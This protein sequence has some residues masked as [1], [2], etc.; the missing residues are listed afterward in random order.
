MSEKVLVAMSGG[1]DSSVAVKLLKSQG[2][3]CSGAIM[4]LCGNENT[5]D[6]LCVA[7]NVGVPF[8]CLDKTEKFKTDV[9]DKFAE[10]YFGGLTPNPCIECNKKMK[11]GFFL[12]YALEN[13]FDF[14]A[15]GHYARV[16]FNE[17][18]GLYELLRAADFSKDQSYVLYF[19]NQTQLQ[20]ILFPLGEYKKP[21]I[22]EMAENYSFVNAKKKDSQ[23]I[24]FVPSGDYAE[25]AEKIYGKKSENGNFKDING[26][27]LGA[28]KGIIHYTIGQR[29]GLGIALGKPTFVISKSTADNSVVLGDENYLFYKKVFV[30]DIN[31]ISG[32]SE[33]MPFRAQVKLR[34]AMQPQ[35]ATVTKTE[36]GAL[37]EFDI[38]Q[39]APSAG[40]AAVFYNGDIVL[41]GGTIVKGEN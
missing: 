13:G 10:D 28:H 31:L 30:K 33:F 8:C 26:K 3:I 22:R 11:F 21:E 14:I 4:R 25:V 15:T 1:V 39:R 35:N 7:E 17:S 41:G 23:D 18:T 19:L 20:H 40:Q 37:V 16:R 29:K 27:I 32:E 12:D 2:Y 9:M 24:C 6:A 38:P 36:S 5:T 34:Y